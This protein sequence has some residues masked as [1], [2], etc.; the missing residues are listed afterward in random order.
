MT[1]LSANRQTPEL[2]G[3]IHDFDMAANAVMFAGSLAVINAAGYAAPGTTALGLRAA[4]R[5]EE[6]A[7]NTGGANGAK[8]ARIKPGVFRFANSAAGDLIA[9][10]DIG[11]DCY[12]VDDQTVAKTSATNTRSIAG[13]IVNVDAQG[14]WVKVGFAIQG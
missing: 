1:A 13:K 9:A 3:G 10:A 2:V 5:V 11:N 4:G 7:N 8:K 12:I 6:Y 14:V